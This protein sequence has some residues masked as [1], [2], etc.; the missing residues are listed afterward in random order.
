MARVL[1]HLRG[2]VAVWYLDDILIPAKDTKDMMTRLEA[3]LKYYK[4]L[5]SP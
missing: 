3:V 2:S 4:M 1:G 5:S